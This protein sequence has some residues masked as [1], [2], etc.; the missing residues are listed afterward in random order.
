MRQEESSLEKKVTPQDARQYPM[1]APSV[2]RSGGRLKE[3]QRIVILTPE[4]E[5]IQEPAAK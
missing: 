2:S 4:K 5:R 1:T 3:K